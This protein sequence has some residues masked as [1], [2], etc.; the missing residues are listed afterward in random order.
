MKVKELIK[1]LSHYGNDDDFEVVIYNADSMGPEPVTG[2]L[3]DN[4][5]KQVELCSDDIS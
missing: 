3:S 5:S 4:T 2:C 1:M